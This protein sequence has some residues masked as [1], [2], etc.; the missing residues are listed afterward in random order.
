MP[1]VS[2]KK[3]DVPFLLGGAGEVAIDTGDLALHQP[4][5]EGMPVLLKVGFKADGDEKITLGRDESLRIGVSTKAS[6]ELTPVF[7]TSAAAA[8]ILKAYGV[9]DFFKDGANS[10]KVVLALIAGAGADIAA[11]GS[12]A[13]STLKTT[14]RLETGADAGYAY[15][16]AL[17][18]NTAVE[19]ILPR[20]FA[21]M[22]LPEQTAH[23]P[24]AGEAISLTYGGYLR[25]AAEVSAGYTLAG[26]KSFSV[27]QLA[28]SEKYDLSVLGKV[29]LAAGVA[30]RF[31][32]LVTATDDLPGWARVQVRRHRA[33]DF[34]IAA[35]VN[36]G[37]KNELDDLPP[38]ANEFLGAVLGVNAKNFL[39]VLHKAAG[40]SDSKKLE[41]AIDGLAKKYVG[42]LIGK[43]FDALESHEEFTSFLDEVN[44]IV[45]SYQQLEDRAITLFDR[46]FDRPE[47]LAGFLEKLQGLNNDGFEKLRSELDPKS[48]TVLSQLT[49]GDPL[50]VLSRQPRVG[51]L[52]S[53]G[54][55]K[56]RAGK[57]L[58]LIRKPA[59]AGIRRAIGIA[60]RQFGFDALFAELAK[61]D[62]PDELQALANEK[63]G[64]FVTRLVGRTL[65]SSANVKEAFKEVQAV[66]ARIDAF[67]EKLFKTFK[68]A[69]SSSYK[70]ALHAEYTRASETDS[71]IDVN[72]NLAHP[73]GPDFLALAGKGD[74]ER[75]I[76]TSDAA[77]VRLQEGVL[78]HRTRR[79]SAFKVNIVG[80]HLNYRYEGFDRVITETEQRLI[81]S[82]QGITVF[83]TATLGVERQRKRQG[84][85]MHMNFLLRALGQSA[86]AVKSDASTLAYLIDALTSL[87]ARYELAF[88][89]DDT[90]E[91][92]L[93]DY[94]GFA[95]DLAL[96]NKGATLAEL[97]P[98]LPRAPNGG[99]GRIDAS[100][101]VRFGEDALQALLAVKELSDSAAIRIRDAMR[102]IVLSNYLKSQ[103][104]HD[105]AFAYATPVVFERFRQEGFAAFTNHS[106]REFPVKLPVAIAAPARVV[107]DRFEL[108]VLSTLY[109][110]ENSMLDAIKALYE[111]LRGPAIDPDRF[112]KRLGEFGDALNLFD[113]FDQTTN[114]RGVG[115]TTIFAMFDMLVRLAA[116]PTAASI[117]LLRLK[118]RAGEREVEKIFLSDAAGIDSPQKLSGRHAARA[119]TP[120]VSDI[121]PARSGEGEAEARV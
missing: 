25:L 49:D 30:G 11:T 103:E 14:V 29:G 93:Q 91:M 113:R 36:V 99:F 102:L 97:R 96:D 65:D 70:V 111:L 52:D 26:T 106:Q 40:L 4:I 32:I 23:A 114:K 109:N 54:E 24:E 33:Q 46:F 100:Y 62:T 75:I 3:Q 107:L 47:E 67:P 86:N 78:T 85:E 10:D 16:R 22:R 31:S 104:Q 61:I 60:K 7:S 98:L 34:K 120:D 68:E 19:T 101:D 82:D 53:R 110:I 69:A 112:E 42:E 84:E 59:H 72:I 92:E 83:T 105:V 15:L 74:F 66:L 80:W 45:T 118:S 8:R 39:N 71:L 55:L 1:T 119:P 117:A 44:G 28:L 115:T 57:A 63:V 9:G 37:F 12:F 88:T 38:N 6:L 27:G 13:Y 81:P 41:E 5:K 89:D 48:W 20:F 51:G 17:D 50:A 94:L 95:A 56:K 43:G 35:D 2:L 116:G 58:D 21:T 121:A 79:A 76:G 73:R 77:L 108:N 90:S 18:K 64:L 87:T